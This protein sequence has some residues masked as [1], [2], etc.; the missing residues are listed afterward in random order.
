MGDALGIVE[1][2]GFAAAVQAA[3]A[4]AKT[5]GVRLAAYEKVGGGYVS[6]VVRGE[7][8]AVRAALDVG[9]REAERAG[10]VV[11]VVFIPRIHAS[12][13]ALMPLGRD[14]GG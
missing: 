7:A 3:D 1:T 12:L 8:A 4:M 2:L 11:G 6:V 5:A 9:Q 13:E 10:R 14:A